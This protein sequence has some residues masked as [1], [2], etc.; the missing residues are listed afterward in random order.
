MVSKHFLTSC[1]CL[2][3]LGSFTLS[4]PIT[5]EVMGGAPALVALAL[6]A[7]RFRDT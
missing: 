5:H 6:S 1:Y 2:M 4:T 7:L 3:F